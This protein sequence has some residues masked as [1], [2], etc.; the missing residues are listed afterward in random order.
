MGRNTRILKAVTISSL[1]IALVPAGVATAGPLKNYSQNGATGDYAP[2]VAH[3]NYALN[4]AT[5]DYTPPVS[6]PQSAPVIT[7]VPG[8]S[9]FAWGDAA[10]GA[11]VALLGMSLVLFTSRRVRRRRIPAPVPARPSAV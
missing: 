4:G 3:K 5:G 1:V 8:D 7:T 11:A 6:H 2:Q 10:I 9:G